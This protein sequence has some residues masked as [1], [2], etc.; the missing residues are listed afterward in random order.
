MEVLRTFRV[1]PPL[2]SETVLEG[3]DS[4][5][6]RVGPGDV[7]LVLENS[8]TWWSIVEALPDPSQHRVG[9][10]AWGLGASFTRS[11]QSISK[12]HRITEI[13]YFG[14][15]DLSGIRIPAQAAAV[16]CER[17]LPP[18]VPATRFYQALL[19][20]G[21]PAP[22]REPSAR[23]RAT[24]HMGWLN[25]EHCTA[26]AELLE[27]GARLAQEWVGLRYL[28]TSSEWHEDLR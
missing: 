11:V 3:T 8:T 24:P 2:L 5:Y 9:H 22:S 20:L 26:V 15:L 25:P 14:D 23:E 10:V 27:A 28:T 4:G 16:A 6:R 19:A 17:G 18:V 12:R 1:P 7:L 13:R 21:R